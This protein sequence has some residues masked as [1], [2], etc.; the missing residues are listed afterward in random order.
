MQLFFIVCNLVALSSVVSLTTKVGRVQKV[1]Q[2]MND[3]LV[4]SK[5]AKSEEHKA[6]VENHQ[7]CQSTRVEKDRA[8]SDGEFQIAQLNAMIAKATVDLNTT[9]SEIEV[10]TNDIGVLSS[11]M[12]MNQEYRTLEHADFI[13][14][15]DEYMSAIEAI[16]GALPVLT[17]SPGQS[18]AQVKDSLVLTSLTLPS[19]AGKAVIAFINRSHDPIEVLV[20]RVV[21]MV[22][23]LSK[24]FKDKKYELEKL[25]AQDK[26][27]SNVVEQDLHARIDRSTQERLSK[28]GTQ[29]QLEKARAEAQRRLLATTASVAAHTQYLA[30]LTRSCSVEAFEYHENQSVHAAEINTLRKAIEIM[31][32]SAV[33]S[34]SKHFPTLVQNGTSLVQSCS[35]VQGPMQVAILLSDHAHKVKSQILSFV[36]K[37]VAEVPRQKGK[38]MIQ[39]MILKLTEEAFDEAEHTGFCDPDMI[40]IDTSKNTPDTKTEGLNASAAKFGSEAADLSYQINYLEN[41]MALATKIRSEQKAHNVALLADALAASM[42]TAQAL[43]ILKDFYGENDGSDA[44]SVVGMLEA[45]ESDFIRLETQTKVA[46]D[47]AEKDYTTFK[48]TSSQVKAVKSTEISYLKNLRPSDVEAGAS[49]KEHVTRRLAE[50]DVL[51]DALKTL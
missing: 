9:A 13:S 26:H 33:T 31:S 28:M 23:G 35:A 2:M 46:E 3:M 50:I 17:S 22:E 39:E 16:D 47:R 41:E 32:V 18:F 49:Y 11:Q 14:A 20:E 19:N 38:K 21:G 40:Q 36:A 42:A 37:R 10:L 30:V 5:N 12:A 27:R 15:H 45:I 29:A 24:K 25:E 7:L 6:F 8:V 34:G 44:A 48:R 51:A 4:K 43:Q 1:S